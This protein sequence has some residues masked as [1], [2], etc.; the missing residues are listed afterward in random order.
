MKKACVIGHFGFGQK[1]LNG[2]TVKA[3][4]VADAL[5]KHYGAEAIER[6]DS[7]C[8]RGALWNLLRMPFLTLRAVR[9]S[10]NVVILPAEN[11]LRVI[12]PLLSFWN[13]FFRRGLHYAVIG[14]WLAPFLET[15]KGLSRVLSR[16]RGIYVE[17][18][19]MQK[20]LN[21]MGLSNVFLMPNCKDLP[22]LTSEEVE[23]PLVEP[24][25][26]CTFSRVMREKGIEDAVTAVS[27]ANEALGRTAFTL[28]IYGQVDA[29]Q[30]EWFDALQKTFPEFVRYGGLVPYTESVA[31]LKGS[32]ALLFPTHFYTEGI[33]G[34]VIDAYAAGVP[35]ISARWESFSDII[36]EGVTGIGFPMQDTDALT[37]L[38]VE[39]SSSP[40]RISSL[41]E[42]CL[43]AAREYTP[44]CA[45]LAL[46][47]RMD[48]A[49]QG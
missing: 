19:T 10:E 39:L 23:L 2:Q 25:R 30:T 48:A 24:Y 47:E 43:R 7:H 12:A 8:T 42:G 16:F 33:P 21:G 34:T 28:E 4:I 3:H 35:V 13:A 49:K 27:R 40:E 31:T 45:I 11:G 37:K 9:K 14:G 41:R 1:L 29:A 20:A 6:I 5:A 36:R 15:R 17:T 26:L 44:E 22:I 38:L 32:A 46:T 18:S